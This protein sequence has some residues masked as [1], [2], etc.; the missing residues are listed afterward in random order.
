MPIGSTRCSQ[1]RRPGVAAWRVDETSII[2]RPRVRFIEG[3]LKAAQR[4]G[5]R[6][7]VGRDELL[8]I[9]EKDL[10]GDVLRQ[11]ERAQKFEQ[12][13]AVVVAREEQAI[14][15]AEDE[16]AAVLYIPPQRS[17]ARSRTQIRVEIW[18][19]LEQARHLSAL[20]DRA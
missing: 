8:R 17:Q 15:E 4:R 20:R 16:F 18:I 6:F 14:G 13:A 5:V 19:F 10:V 9:F 2:R 1:R 3:V 12:L 7:D 11:I